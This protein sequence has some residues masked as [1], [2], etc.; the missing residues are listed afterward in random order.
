MRL[1][2]YTIDLTG[3]TPGGLQDGG[4]QGEDL[5]AALVFTP[6]EALEEDISG[7]LP[8]GHSIRYRV[9]TTDGCGG[10]H[11]SAFLTPD[12]ATGAI[13]YPLP[14][15]ITLAG[16]TASCYLVVSELDQELVEVRTLYSFPAR[17]AFAASPAGSDPQAA[18]E[19]KL[20]GALAAA[21]DAAERTETLYEESFPVTTPNIADGAVTSTKIAADAVTADKIPMKSITSERIKDLAITPLQLAPGAVIDS[22]IADGAVTTSKL[23]PGAVTKE[24]IAGGSIDYTK[25]QNNAVTADKLAGD[26]VTTPKL[27]DGAVTA[28]KLAA[29]VI[30]AFLPDNKLLTGAGGRC[31][32]AVAY[33]IIDAESL[34][35]RITTGDSTITLYV[36]DANPSQKTYT[37]SMAVRLA[38]GNPTGWISPSI[39][40]SAGNRTQWDGGVS[41]ITPSAEWQL[42][43]VS[44]LQGPT[45]IKLITDMTDHAQGSS[46]TF[47]MVNPQILDTDGNNA[48]DLSSLSGIS[49]TFMGPGG[50]GQIPTLAYVQ[51]L[52]DQQG[53]ADG[54][55]TTAKLADG[56]VTAAKLA[57]DALPAA[58]TSQAGLVQLNNTLTS[59]A[60][61]QALTA[62]Q[63][64]TLSEKMIKYAVCS[65]TASTAAKTLSVSGFSLTAGA[66]VMV[67]FTNGNTASSPTLNINSTGAKSIYRDGAS[68]Y[69][70]SLAAGE[71][72]LLVYDGTYYRVVDIPDASTYRAGKVQLNNTL[73]SS[74]TTQALT[75][76]QGKALNDKVSEIAF[77]TGTFTLTAGTGTSTCNY[78]KVGKLVTIWGS[79]P[80]LSTS[81]SVEYATGLPFTPAKN[82]GAFY[83]MGSA[84]AGV[85]Y[86]D[87]SSRLYRVDPGDLDTPVTTAWRGQSFT[88]TYITNA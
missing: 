83:G 62:A 22:K 14:L 9:D 6:T 61:A 10:F 33:D 53:V 64:K 59:T 13:T 16:G 18:Y 57:D 34:C 7:N 87:T 3:I 32:K 12:T 49:E 78:F 46:Y 77:D 21:L 79:L 35:Y 55:V 86:A 70:L 69:G 5:A 80:A 19:H 45:D 51:E 67:Q 29:D 65:T 26:A 8:Q 31:L 20:G 71:A 58:S 68:S 4:V 88:L 50:S 42:C 37:L 76:A 63:G 47:D 30:P 73:T 84:N 85:M 23:A 82:T 56:A 72:V 74:S 25:L 44:N 2:H 81:T 1:I 15:E 66:A 40:T 36:T 52:M 54:S 28:D 43:T 39:T 60:T 41:R 11:A 75:A 27:A 24:K 38:S 17:I 48:I